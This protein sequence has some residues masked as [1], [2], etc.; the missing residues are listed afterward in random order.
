MRSKTYFCPGFPLVE[1]VEVAGPFV[2]PPEYWTGLFG[3]TQ[4]EDETYEI[5]VNIRF[6][7]NELNPLNAYASHDSCVNAILKEV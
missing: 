5:H 3:Q 1:A 2:L 4:S 7:Y 6:Q